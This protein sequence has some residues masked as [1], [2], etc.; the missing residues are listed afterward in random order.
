MM[1]TVMMMAM[2]TMMTQIVIKM[3]TLIM[4]PNYHA[5][6]RHHHDGRG[7]R[8]CGDCKRHGHDHDRKQH[9]LKPPNP[10]RYRSH[11]HHHN[12][13]SVITLP[14]VDD[15]APEPSALS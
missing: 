13:T 12:K 3:I 1:M 11:R 5:V 14:I 7:Y 2:M 9:H 6:S 4:I 8:G 15:V 10:R